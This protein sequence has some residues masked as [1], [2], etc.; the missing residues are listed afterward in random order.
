[1]GSLRSLRIPRRRA[2][3]AASAVAMVA[4]AVLWGGATTSFARGGGPPP[5]SCSS[6]L[7]FGV[8]PDL[9]SPSTASLVIWISPASEWLQ[10]WDGESWQ[11]ITTGGS[12]YG[13]YTDTGLSVGTTYSY[14]LID[15]SGVPS[16]PLSFTTAPAS[17]MVKP[18]VTGGSR[19]SVQVNPVGWCDDAGSC[20]E[21]GGR[22]PFVGSENVYGSRERCGTAC[23]TYAASAHFTYPDRHRTPLAVVVDPGFTVQDSF[24]NGFGGCG[25][26]AAWC[27]DGGFDWLTGQT[28][29]S[30]SVSSPLRLLCSTWPATPTSA[31][32]AELRVVN[33]ATPN[34]AWIYEVRLAGFTPACVPGRSTARQTTYRW[35]QLWTATDT[36][37]LTHNGR[38]V[39][40]AKLGTVDA[41]TDR[42]WIFAHGAG[43]YTLRICGSRK[44]TN[45][46]A[47]HACSSTRYHF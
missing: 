7:I 31:A 32:S 23:W 21:G 15:G 12:C 34:Q 6:P 42:S 1:M 16:S 43:A 25:L 18:A 14:R 40:S 33:A 47:I 41:A 2:A 24:P 9:S 3:A 39:R 19:Q 44:R 20:E 36:I 30:L 37:T 22:G 46:S 8:H 29:A 10:R 35:G 4:L 17:L 13:S 5:P 45:A 26:T 38:V 27:S 28:A 11:T